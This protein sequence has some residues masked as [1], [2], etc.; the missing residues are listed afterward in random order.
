MATQPPPIATWLLRH[1]GCGPNNDAVIGDLDERYQCGRARM[2]YW[3]QAS[4]A[5][6]ISFMKEIWSHKLLTLTAILY[7]WT[8]FFYIS[9]F[10]Y[11]LTLELFSAIAGGPD[12]GETIP[13]L[14]VQLSELVLCG[15][16]SGWLV[17]RLDR[18]NHKAMVLANAG[19]FAAFYSVHIVYQ[20]LRGKGH[21]PILLVIV[22]IPITIL[23][24]G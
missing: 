1:F 20:M 14:A 7:G 15:M 24:G 23:V 11:Y 9:R 2:W 6:V 13:R 8:V 5:I 17:A 3:Q 4:A 22:I 16:L 12:I 18:R 21:V 10:N 19:Y